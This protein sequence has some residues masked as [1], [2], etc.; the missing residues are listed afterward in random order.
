MI[1]Q[2]DLTGIGECLIELSEESSHHYHQ[3]IAGDVFNTLFYANRLGLKTGFISSFGADE[4]TEN[5]WRVMDKEGIDRNCTYHSKKNNNGLYIIS[6]RKGKEPH[7]SF[8]REDSAAKY[9]L[10]VLES[11]Q[12]LDYIS[13]SRYFHFSAIALAVLG[14]A[15]KFLSM[16]KKISKDTIITFDTNYRKSQ[17]GDNGKLRKFLE[18]ASH[19]IDFIFISRTDDYHIFGDREI[20]E[21]IRHY[22]FMG[23]KTIIFRQG[24]GDVYLY[25]N[26]KIDKIPAMQN[27]REVDPTAA[28][29]AFNAGFIS[30]HLHGMNME[31]CVRHGN[32]CAAFVIERKGAIA[33][34]FHKN[35]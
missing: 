10:N 4:F 31:D 27:V 12:I 14:D 19:C 23:Y 2:F 21:A 25:D 3:S 16:L 32:A 1:K 26:G 9:I 5:I 20:E 13:H 11:K 17:W 28:G 29:D 8:W 7:Y 35:V 34:D 18:Q 33:W 22:A 15:E 30:S 6:K 24:K